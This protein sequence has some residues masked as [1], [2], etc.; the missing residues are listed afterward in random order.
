MNASFRPDI[1]GLRAIAVLLVIAAHFDLPG[2]SGGFIGVDI[3]FVISGYLITSILFKEQSSSGTIALG[4]FYTRRLRRLLPA[5]ATMLVVTSLLTSYLLHE[6]QYQ[7]QGIATAMAVVW[8]SNIYFTFSDVDYFGD[9]NT[10]NAV[11]HTWSLGVEEQFYLIWPLAILL[12]AHYCKGRNIHITAIR[13]FT[14]ITL[15]SFCACMLFSVSDPQFSFYMMPTRAWQFSAG[16]LVW[17]LSRD[18]RPSASIGVASASSGILLLLVALVI[19]GP[20]ALYPGVLALLPTLA[21]CLLLWAGSTSRQTIIG[22]FLALKPMQ[23]LGRRSYSWYLWHWPVLI[24][25]EQLA[26]IRGHLGHTLL[27]LA[28]SL[29]AAILT[30]ALIENPIRYGTAA[31]LK[32]RWQIVLA[33]FTMLLLNSQFLKWQTDTQRQLATAN[34]AFVRALSDAPS[35]YKQGCDSWYQNADLQPCIYGGEN[36]QK[37]AVLIGDSIGAQ[38]LPALERALDPAQWRL[39]VLTK[40]S[41]P[42]VDEPYFYARIGRE[43]TECAEWREKAIEWLQQ[44]PVDRLFIGSTASN[45]FTDEQW[46]EGTRRILDKLA[47]S[48]QAIF[49]IEAN[50]TL[51]MNGP[52]CL[53][54]HGTDHQTACQTPA[55][56]AQYIHVAELLRAVAETQPNTYWLPTSKLVCPDGQCQAMRGATVVYRDSQ[57]LT[58]NF[59]ASTAPYFREQIQRHEKAT[60]E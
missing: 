23:W 51:S 13:F 21:T 58:A 39:I 40:S 2:F 24:I 36:A 45:A 46:Q 56:P 60:Q 43:Y 1:E 10:S 19:I 33:V 14:A 37:T 26:P 28:V 35:I 6:S 54:R 11:L 25:G 20:N 7:E 22:R 50:P 55:G 32:T 42:M 41:C 8:L 48:A 34:Q 16:A 52:Q 4:R 49:L 15:I 38:W 30:Y 31:R 44:Q 3:F 17:L 27:A 53:M 18:K 29:L 47:G 12:I 59:V 57:H 9:E 5:L